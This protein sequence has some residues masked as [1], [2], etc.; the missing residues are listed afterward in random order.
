MLAVAPAVL[1]RRQKRLNSSAG[2]LADAATAKASATR[3]AM[4]SR[5][6]GIASAIATAPMPNAATRTTI[7]SLALRGLA[8]LDHVGVEVVGH[9]RGRRQGQPG[10]DGE[11]RR[12]GD[13]GD[14]REQDRAAERALAT[15]DRLGEQR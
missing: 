15:A 4:F 14:E 3:K 13:G 5:W 2:R 10:D 11:D 7:I 1:N 8:L 6:A 12:E 9:R